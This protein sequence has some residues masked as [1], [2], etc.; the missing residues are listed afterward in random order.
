MASTAVPSPA[1]VGRRILGEIEESS[2]EDVLQRIRAE[3]VARAKAN[4]RTLAATGDATQHAGTAYSGAVKASSPVKNSTA[5][6]PPLRLPIFPIPALQQLVTRHFRSTRAPE[7]VVSGQRPLALV[8]LLVATLVAA[9]RRQTVVV[10]DAEA[11][12]KVR[13]MLG[14]QPMASSDEAEAEVLASPVTEDDLQHVHV[15]RVDSRWR[16]PL[17]E[18]VAAA[19]QREVPVVEESQ[20]TLLRL[21]PPTTTIRSVMAWALHSLQDPTAGSEFIVKNKI[22]SKLTKSGRISCWNF[23]RI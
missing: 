21:A 17:A 1:L 12:F 9:P 16:V 8:Y 15:F 10:V 13:Q 20:A 5:A 6:A 14:V 3:T 22:R 19:E 23:Y 2:L 7:L 18:L 11:R 4:A